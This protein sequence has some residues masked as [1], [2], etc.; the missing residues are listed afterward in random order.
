MDQDNWGRDPAVQRMRWVFAE[1]EQIQKKLLDQLQISSFDARLRSVRETARSLFDRAMDH[2]AEKGMRLTD[3]V[4]MD[5]FRGCLLKVLTIAGIK[6]P[7]ELWPG[8]RV[9]R[10]LINEVSR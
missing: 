6:I 1:M 7:Q 9:V 4:M 8:D 3:T 10:E 5:I 2:A